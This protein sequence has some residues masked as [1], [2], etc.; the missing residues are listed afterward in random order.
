[1]I[2]NDWPAAVYLAV[3]ATSDTVSV[4]VYSDP[5]DRRVETTTG[6][7]TDPVPP[8]IKREEDPELAPGEEVV[9]M[10]MGGPGFTI[11]YTRRVYR[12][13][14]LTRDERWTWTY[15]PENALVR[16]G[17]GTGTS[18]APDADGSTAPDDPEAPAAP[19]EP[20]GTG[21]GSAQPPPPG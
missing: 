17:P 14:T 9:D 16:V 5:L 1:V 21:T 8:E 4:R 3:T 15:R 19:R 6:E 11:A 18:T 12:G 13:E 2:R 20:D 10:P 7:P